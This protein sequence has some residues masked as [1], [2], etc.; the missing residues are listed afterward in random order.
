MQVPPNHQY[1]SA[2]DVT[3]AVPIIFL[4]EAP[5]L[6]AAVLL[7]H[8]SIIQQIMQQLYYSEAGASY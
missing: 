7:Y 1:A 3:S 5:L 8:L 2:T 4:Y 6:L